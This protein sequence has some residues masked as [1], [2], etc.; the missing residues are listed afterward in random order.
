LASYKLIG[1]NKSIKNTTS[2]NGNVIDFDLAL[3][4]DCF[5]VNNPQVP[6]GMQK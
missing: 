3:E 2:E 6:D 4:K 1:A 5:Y